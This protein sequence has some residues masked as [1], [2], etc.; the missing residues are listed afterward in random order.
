MFLRNL[1]RGESPGDAN[2]TLASKSR[3]IEGSLILSLKRK[4]S[5][6]WTES[7]GRYLSLSGDI[8]AILRGMPLL[9]TGDCCVHMFVDTRESS[10]Y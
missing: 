5:T 7:G 6:Y 4:P 2:G 8:T 1:S 10:C 3:R 9:N